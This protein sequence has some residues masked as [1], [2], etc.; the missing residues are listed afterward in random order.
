MISFRIDWF[1][2]LDVQGTLKSLLQHNSLKAS[3]LADIRGL[4]TPTLAELAWL[5]QVPL[6]PG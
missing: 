5:Q 2:L 6:G 3:I 4:L 1:D